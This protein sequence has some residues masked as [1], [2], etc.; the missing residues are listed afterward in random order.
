MVRGVREGWAEE[1]REMAE[2]GEDRLLDS[3][4]PTT[5]DETEWEWPID[6]TPDT[7]ALRREAA[8]R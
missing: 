1:A 6:H 2:R 3:D 7:S 8:D 5:F 4:V